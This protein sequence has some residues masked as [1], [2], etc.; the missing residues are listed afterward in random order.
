MFFIFLLILIG[1]GF[2]GLI[3]FGMIIFF[4]IVIPI[5]I[6]SLIV[7]LIRYLYFRFSGR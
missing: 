4:Y 6:I 3:A 7:R 5:I 2:C 1:M